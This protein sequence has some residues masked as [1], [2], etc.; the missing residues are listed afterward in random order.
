VIVRERLDQHLGIELLALGL[1][2]FVS[3]GAGDG[4]A[5]SARQTPFGARWFAPGQ[6]GHRVRCQK[7]S[8][9]TFCLTA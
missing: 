2:A 3:E 9:L 1:S 7:L 5:A 8:T 6:A 4:M